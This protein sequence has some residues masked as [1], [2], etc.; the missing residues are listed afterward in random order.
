[1]ENNMKK[2]SEEE[3]LVLKKH[4][5][6]K[7]NKEETLVYQKYTES[8]I[9]HLIDKPAIAKCEAVIKVCKQII[10]EI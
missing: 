8:L 10:E 3:M 7:Y 5:I 1:M 4:M 2:P 9:P 6:K